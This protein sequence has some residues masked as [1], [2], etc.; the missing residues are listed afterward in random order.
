[1]DDEPGFDDFVAEQA[2]ALLR[3]GYVLSGNPHD[4]ADL[5]QEALA[6]LRG[7]WSRV[8]RKADARSYARTTMARLHT[9]IWRR[10]RREHLTGEPPERA[11]D[12]FF[13]SDAEEGLWRALAALPR[14]QRAVLV[15]RY[16]EQLSDTEIAEVLGISTGTVRSQAS[17]GL[18]KLRSSLSLT[19][20][21]HG[22]R[23]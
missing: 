23:R 12:A 10:R 19:K 9:S 16:Y 17:R 4:A 21:D 18:D 7:A 11:S 8:R 6:R 15:L 20:A 22:S 1:M 13:P 3:Y 14:K 2:D 5:T